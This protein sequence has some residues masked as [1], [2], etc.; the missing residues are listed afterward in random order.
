MVTIIVRSNAND[1]VKYYHHLSYISLLILSYLVFYFFLLSYNIS[2]LLLD[3]V[4]RCFIIMR[5]YNCIYQISTKKQ[6]NTIPRCGF[7]CGRIA[8]GLLKVTKITSLRL[9][10]TC[11]DLVDP[12]RK[13]EWIP[14]WLYFN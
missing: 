4:S 2:E 5:D 1:I 9:C 7:S 10:D 11:Y 3:L 6:E 12:D 8:M 14:F 13:M